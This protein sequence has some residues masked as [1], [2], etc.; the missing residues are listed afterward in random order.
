MKATKLFSF[1]LALCA[2]S[3]WAVGGNWVPGDTTTEW[4]DDSNWQ[5]SG[6]IVFGGGDSSGK[7]K[8]KNV[9]VTFTNRSSV[10]GGSFFIQNDG[11]LVT[12][13]ADSSADRTD[14]HSIFTHMSD[15]R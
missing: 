12:F 7:V 5:G 13:A 1:M 8:D 11:G 10:V 6:N 15:W 4:T 14:F 3:A 9:T 2:S